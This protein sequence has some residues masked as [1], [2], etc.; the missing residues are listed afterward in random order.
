MAREGVS[1]PEN[2]RYASDDDRVHVGGYLGIN[3]RFKDGNWQGSYKR[4]DGNA[5]G[6]AD[7]IDQ[8][9]GSRW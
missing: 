1:G 2:D 8:G 5:Y 9:L 7:H 4:H 3:D 6:R